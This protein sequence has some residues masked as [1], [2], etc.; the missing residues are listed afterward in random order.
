MREDEQITAILDVLP[1]IVGL[2][3]REAVLG[4][5]DDQQLRLLD[6]LEIYGILVEANLPSSMLYLVHF[7]VFLHEFLEVGPGIADL[8]LAGVEDY[9]ANATST[10]F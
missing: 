7:L 2:G 9:L 6:L 5:S 10:T 4:R 8:L 3:G 1:E